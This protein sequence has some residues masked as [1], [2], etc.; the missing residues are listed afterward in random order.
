MTEFCY[1]EVGGKYI[2]KEY[3]SENGKVYFKYSFF[4]EKEA[5]TFIEEQEEIMN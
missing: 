5:L 2:V 4:T 1:K 3:N